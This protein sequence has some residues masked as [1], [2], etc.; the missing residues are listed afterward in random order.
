MI[1]PTLYQAEM[2]IVNCAEHENP[3]PAVYDVV[4]PVCESGDFLGKDRTLDVRQGDVLAMLG[5]GAYGMSMASNYNA[6][7]RAAEVMVKGETAYLI[8]RRET[9]EDQMALES[10]LP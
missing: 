6:R 7:G 5:A 1:R 10:R 4:G 8:R 9:I 2:T 3:T